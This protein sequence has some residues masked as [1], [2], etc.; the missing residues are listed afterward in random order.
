M[1][2]WMQTLYCLQTIWSSS[3]RTADYQTLPFQGKVNEKK[4][5]TKTR[6]RGKKFLKILNKFEH[7][8]VDL[9]GLL[10]QNFCWENPLDFNSTDK[11]KEEKLHKTNEIVLIL[12]RIIL[13]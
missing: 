6:E 3:K 12:E 7:G 13:N 10:L 1:K 8:S 5:G 11:T 4:K 2:N 9:H